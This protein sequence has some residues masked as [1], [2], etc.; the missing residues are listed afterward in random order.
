MQAIP[1]CSISVSYNRIQQPEEKP[2]TLLST[3]IQK[4][5]DMS[6]ATSCV[7]V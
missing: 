5:R 4:E 3:R 1:S 6:Q 7:G 2:S